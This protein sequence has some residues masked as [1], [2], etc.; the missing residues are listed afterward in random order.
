MPT[1]A[2]RPHEWGTRTLSFRFEY[3][4]HHPDVAFA[5]DSEGGEEVGEDEEIA[6]LG[7]EVA[8]L[9]GDPFVFG[10]DVDTDER[11]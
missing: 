10:A 2:M 7:A 5:S 6:D 8:E 3:P 11:A 9:E 1:H 4:L